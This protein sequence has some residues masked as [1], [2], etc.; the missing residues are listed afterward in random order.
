MPL[1]QLCL[2]LF[3]RCLTFALLLSGLKVAA[4]SSSSE[5]KFPYRNWPSRSD[6]PLVAR[7]WLLSFNPFG[8][9]EPAAALGAG[10]GYRYNHSAEFWSETSFLWL[11]GKPSQANAGV[12]SGWRQILQVKLFCD[13]DGA[14]FVAGEV[15]YRNF[16]HRLYSGFV[17]K[18]ARSV[19]KNVLTT[20]YHKVYG[21]A[22]QLGIGRR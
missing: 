21:A 7:R 1:A 19:M 12:I 17:D 2:L 20:S 14:F 9:L 8:F 3:K 22:L 5:Y 16:S 18:V 15:R 6:E 13:K 11:P 4:Q 10:F